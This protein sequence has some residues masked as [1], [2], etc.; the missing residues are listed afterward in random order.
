MNLKYAQY[1]ASSPTIIVKYLDKLNKIRSY[2]KERCF[3]LNISNLFQKMYN[4]IFILILLFSLS[5]TQFTQSQEQKLVE[6]LLKGYS[7]IIR[8][9]NIVN[10]ILGVELKQIISVDEK[11]Q[12]LSTN[13]F[14]SQYWSD[15]RLAWN[16]TDNNGTEILM[17]PL[18][19]VWAP[20]TNIINSAN[21]DGYLKL[22]SD[23]SYVSVYYTGDVYYVSSVLGL[24]TR[25]DLDM[26]KWPFD[27]QKCTIRV[28]S[29]S[30]EDDKLIYSLNESYVDIGDF[31][32]H[33]IW[34]LDENNSELK[35]S[36]KIG[37]VPFDIYNS[38]EIN[39]ILSLRRKPLYYMINTMFPCF[40]L[41]LVTLTLLFMPASNAFAICK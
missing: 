9:S 1:F 17:I 10:V 24:Q 33:P 28:A 19:S 36:E 23:F 35:T 22:N 21:G 26:R 8:P 7:R 20:D 11:N 4:L 40:I 6:S 14:I 15:P 12:I 41:N 18:K 37:R 27:T 34:T 30:F 32:P 2:I 25:C 3:F 5:D 31:T 13:S 16:T 38:T 39:I 29:W